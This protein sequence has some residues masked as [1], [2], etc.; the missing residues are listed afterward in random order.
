M[1]SVNKCDKNADKTNII[2][3]MSRKMWLLSLLTLAALQLRSGGEVAAHLNV[4]L[5]PVEVMRLLGEFFLF[6]YFYF[7]FFIFLCR[8]HLLLISFQKLNHSPSLSLSLSVK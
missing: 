1:E 3:K 7:F 6:F 2:M 4:F 8:A 5:N